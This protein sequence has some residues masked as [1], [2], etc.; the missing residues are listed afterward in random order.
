MC[1]A[2]VCGEEG[3]GEEVGEGGGRAWASEVIIEL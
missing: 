2:A 1:D 3:L